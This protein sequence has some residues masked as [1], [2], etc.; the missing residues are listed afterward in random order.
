MN[1][2]YKIHVYTASRFDAN[3]STILYFKKEIKQ[4]PKHISSSKLNDYVH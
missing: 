4:K 1:L 2:Y 3:L